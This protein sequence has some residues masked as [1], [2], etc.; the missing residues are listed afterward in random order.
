MNIKRLMDIGCWLGDSGTAGVAGSGAADLYQ[1]PHQEGPETGHR[2]QEE[3]A[4]SSARLNGTSRNGFTQRGLV[5]ARRQRLATPRSGRTKKTKKVVAAE[6][7][8]TSRPPSTTRSSPSPTRRATSWF[9]R[10]RRVSRVQ[11]STPFAATMA[12]EQAG[13]DAV[14]ICPQGRCSRTG[15]GIGPG[16]RHPGA[17]RGRAHDRIDPRRDTPAAQRLPPTQETPRL[18]A[19][20]QDP[21]GI[22]AAMHPR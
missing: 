20:G 18:A 6:V 9:V 22:R 13:R 7:S 15:S 17:L 16:I 2:G 12:A 14:A 11:R 3:G 10:E 21:P 4:Q 1:R 5:P 8:L 19:R